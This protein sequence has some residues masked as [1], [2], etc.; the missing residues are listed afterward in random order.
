ME[1][2][3]LGGTRRSKLGLGWESP[4]L[5]ALTLIALSLGVV[6]VHSASVVKAHDEGLPH[7]YYLIF[8]L[9][10]GA[11]GVLLLVILANID[12]R[13]LRLL[14]WPL[15]LATIAAL[16]LVKFGPEAVSPMTN[17]AKRWL[18]LGP[19]RLQPSEFAKLTLMVWTAALAVKKQEKLRSLTRGLGPFLLMWLIVGVLIA[20]EPSMSAAVLVV[21]LAALV[22]FAAGA[23]IG[24]FVALGSLGLPL[25]ARAIVSAG[26][27]GGRID[28]WLHP[29]N[30]VSGL[31]YQV[32]Q[33]KIA[34]GS[35]GLFGV[36]FGRGQQ[37]FGFLPE[38]HNDFILAMIG[39]EWGFVGVAAVIVLFTLIALIG[40]RI[41]RQAPDLFGC[42]LAIGLTNLIAVPALMHVAVNLSLIPAT[43][44]T[45]PFVSYGRSSL[46]VS[47]AAVGILMNIARQ[48]GRRAE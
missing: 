7:Y 35:G 33:A 36:G 30:D 21:F 41:A 10:G 47:L 43:G 14:A 29:Q 22:V 1:R 27:R 3:E 16:I 42:L 37:K 34:V 12:Y 11:A 32:T 13:R 8:Q 9:L 45:L 6:I 26:Y 31:A 19:L 15:L 4:L 39:E 44:V 23:R 2:L 46:L 24:H 38:P 28:V 17:G 48:S 18:S 40:Y 20:I 5:L 25:L